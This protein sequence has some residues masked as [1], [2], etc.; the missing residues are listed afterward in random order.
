[1]SQVLII[2]DELATAEPVKQALELNGI[3]ADIAKDGVEGLEMF[4]KGDYELVLLDLKLPGMQGEEVLT[5]LRKIDPFID[6]IIYTNYSDF[7]DIKKLANIGIEGYINKGPSAD[8]GELVEAIKRRLAPL[9]N[10]TFVKLI[11]DIK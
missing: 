4:D 3:S 7:A 11:Q 10:D 9:D 5:R 6:V 8:L 1:M 2:E